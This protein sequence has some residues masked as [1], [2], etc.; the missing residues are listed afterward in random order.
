GLDWLFDLGCVTRERRGNVAAISWGRSNGGGGR[1]FGSLGILGFLLSRFAISR[2]S[3]PAGRPQTYDCNHKY[4]RS[5]S[6]DTSKTS[7][8][9]MR[10]QRRSTTRNVMIFQ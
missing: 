4:Q 9:S 7:H 1:L 5:H 2:T 6:T 8:V 3:T 10:R